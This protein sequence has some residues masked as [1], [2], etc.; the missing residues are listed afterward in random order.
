MAIEGVE[1]MT[2]CHGKVCKSKSSRKAAMHLYP[3]WLVGTRASRIACMFH[4]QPRGRARSK[5]QEQRHLEEISR[6]N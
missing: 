4:E 3:P 6:E 1:E 2:G 5:G